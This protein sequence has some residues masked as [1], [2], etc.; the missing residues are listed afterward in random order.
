M[1][2]CLITRFASVRGAPRAAAALL[3]VGVTLNCATPP[4]ETEM[5]PTPPDEMEAPSSTARSAPA[6]A[7]EPEAPP[8]EIAPPALPASD[9][10]AEGT[11]APATPPPPAPEPAPS[12]EEMMAAQ[13]EAR[14]D[15]L[16][17]RMTIEQ[18]VGQRFMTWIPGAAGSER[19]AA[20]IEQAHVG[21]VILIERNVESYEQMRELITD[22]QRMAQAAGPAPLFIA[23]D[24]EGGRVSRI[25]LPE[26]THFPAAYHQGVHA[27][28]DY[29]EAAA[30]VTGVELRRLGVNVNLAPTIDVYG[31]PDDTLIGDR[32][33]GADA[34]LVADL[35]G[36]YVRGADRA[37]VIPVAKHF[38]GHGVTS[39]NSHRS[40]PMVRLTGSERSS[41]LAPFSAAI[42]AGV[43][44]IMVAHILYQDLD[45]NWPASVSP[46]IIDG[47]L[48]DQ[49][50]FDGVVMTDA[51]EIG[52]PAPSLRQPGIVR[53]SFQAGADIILA[54][55]ESDVLPLV[56]EALRLVRT[57]L[58]SQERLD[59]S[60]RR[61]LRVKL[62]AGMT[63]AMPVME[64]G[65]ADTA[66]GDG[67][68]VAAAGGTPAPPAGL[69]A[70]GK[71]GAIELTW[72]DPG[73]AGITGYEFRVRT[74]REH[75]WRRWRP[76]PR[77]TAQT[78][79]HVLSGL[80]NGVVYRVQVRARNAAGTGDPD[81]AWATPR[82]PQPGA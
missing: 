77:S 57:G 8:P 55:R 6:T 7:A 76:I 36:A 43:D 5:T 45:P 46:T 50:G 59:E 4:P 54:G 21:G 31:E 26:M 25:E 82:Q 29:V 58:H 67:G 24:Q 14:V 15:D 28:P 2:R 68:G 44:V 40:L 51:I 30:Y 18:K 33:F 11:A 74:D 19:A 56:R 42:D 32:S 22:L 63:G 17:R 27:D 72:D 73:D 35:A 1:L 64:R 66:P 41:N 80:T 52:E 79:R 9:D 81:E 78:T 65:A 34:G 75:D 69:A 38:P 53:N 71:N 13:I 39:V 12:A 23:T 16:L 60:V 10:A 62:A 61:I 49:L 20:L 3:A 48:R 47:L 70:T 37:G